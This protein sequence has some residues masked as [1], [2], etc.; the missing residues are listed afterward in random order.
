MEGMVRPG[1]EEVSLGEFCSRFAIGPFERGYGRSIGEALRKVLLS[2]LP[3][4]ALSSVS[5]AGVCDD[6]STVPG[7][8]VDMIE[9]GLVLKQV[10]LAPT[11]AGSEDGW[12]PDGSALTELAG[13][14]EVTAGD[15]VLPAG[16]RAANPGLHIMNLSEGASVEMV[17]S[18][19]LGRG[20]MLH[21]IDPEGVGSVTRDR[22]PV[23]T[24]VLDALYSPIESVSVA[25]TETRFG[26]RVDYDEL[27]LEVA[28]DGTLTPSE[29]LSKAVCIVAEHLACVFEAVGGEQLKGRSV[30]TRVGSE[31]VLKRDVRPI[32][33]LNLPMRLYNKVLDHGCGTVGELRCI[34]QADKPARPSWFAGEMMSECAAAV[35]ELDMR[36]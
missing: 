16:L 15:L 18:A 11:G 24:V 32:E 22:V 33:Y 30:F 5:V 8:D 17:L 35:E 1:V 29:A 4:Y 13:P 34:L 31:A 20:C 21:V 6:F 25:V 10:R 3:G 26:S 28:T 19:S 36:R 14:C 27:L 12:M 23:G 9:L 2:S 7:S